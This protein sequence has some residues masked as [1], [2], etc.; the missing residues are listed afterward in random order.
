MAPKKRIDFGGEISKMQPVILREVTKKHMLTILGAGLTFPQITVLDYIKEKGSCKMGRLAEA[1]NMTMSAVTGIV[2]KM[3]KL[4]LVKRVRSSKDRRIVRVAFLKKG[5]EMVKLMNKE[6]K[7]AID[8]L[9]SV[10]TDSEKRVYL[11]LVRKMYDNLRE[12][13]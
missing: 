6:R 7:V 12:K 9:F 1:L 3:I 11:K 10:F 8:S 13:K 5:S 4:K 2:D